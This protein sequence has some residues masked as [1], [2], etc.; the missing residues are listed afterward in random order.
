[1]RIHEPDVTIT[2]FALTIECVVLSALLYNIAPNHS[3]LLTWFL[4]A[5]LSIGLSAL[6]G[7]LLHGFLDDPNTK[8]HRQVWQSTLAVLG[9][10]AIALW[11]LGTYILFGPAS[12]R[13]AVQIAGG[14]WFLYFFYIVFRHPPFALALAFYL[15]AALYVLVAFTLAGIRSEN[16]F[17]FAGTG[18]MTLSLVAA[19][20]Q[21]K[22]IGLHSRLFNHN[23]LYHLI[24]AIA[25]ILIYWAAREIL[26]VPPTVT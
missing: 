12:A 14:V 2:D 26:R 13:M 18:G 6:L 1:M 3:F 10:T 8:A 11:V 25:L 15:P 23:A 21:I 7:G 20:V 19:W 22:R 24:Q 5:F 9:V 16:M 4:V 17:L